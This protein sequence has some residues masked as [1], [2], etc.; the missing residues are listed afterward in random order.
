M[1]YKLRLLN[2]L[3]IPR[4][5]NTMLNNSVKNDA[6]IGIIH[7]YPT[8][9]TTPPTYNSPEMEIYFEY[10]ISQLL[11]AVRETKNQTILDRQKQRA[12]RSNSLG[13]NSIQKLQNHFVSSKINKEDEYKVA[14]E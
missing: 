11:M 14:R 1:A 6:K 10:E 3:E 2:Y 4:I 8:Q 9:A 5:I 13:E 12:K 7:T